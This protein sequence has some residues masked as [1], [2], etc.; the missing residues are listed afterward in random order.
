MPAVRV[1]REGW[2]VNDD[3]VRY[4]NAAIGEGRNFLVED[5]AWAVD[6][7]PSGELLKINETITRR[8]FADT[9]EIIAQRG[10]SAFYE[11]PI[12][13]SMIR[14]IQAANG[15]MTLEDLRNY[16]VAIRE[17]VSMRYGDYLLRSN[18]LPSSGPVAM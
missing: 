3:L 13:E 10:P 6:F 9:L 16:T 17:P 14:A 4:M 1:A 12:A 18:S 2:L 5:S 11:S 7:A 15:T 8:R